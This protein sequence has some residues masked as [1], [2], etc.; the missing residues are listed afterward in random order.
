MKSSNQNNGPLEASAV[1]LSLRQLSIAD[2]ARF[3]AQALEN[4]Q[5]ELRQLETGR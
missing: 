2:W 5:R 1:A 3:G 4:M